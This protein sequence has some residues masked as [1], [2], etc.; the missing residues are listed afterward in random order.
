EN[1]D[2]ERMARGVQTHERALG[3]LGCGAKWPGTLV[4]HEQAVSRRDLDPADHPL[5][6]A[7]IAD[8][9]AQDGAEEDPGHHRRGL[10]SQGIHGQSAS[11]MAT[12]TGPVWDDWPGR[13]WRGVSAGREGEAAAAAG[14][15]RGRSGRWVNCRK[16]S[17]SGPS[18]L[19]RIV[20]NDGASLASSM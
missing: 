19:P 8:Q 9:A 2:L 14:S 18:E 6:E 4:A 13:F 17:M 1:A 10:S 20:R 15:E 7:E 3:R 11:E 5:P 16:S 12:G